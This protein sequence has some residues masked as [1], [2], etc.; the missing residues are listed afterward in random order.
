[1]IDQMTL[2]YINLYGVLGALEELTAL[3][4]VA[5]QMLRGKK[6]IRLGILVKGG[7]SA[8][9]AFEQ[10]R[11]TFIEGVER[12]DIKLAFGTPEK[13]NGM[14]AGTVTPIP[15]KG[16]THLFF[17]TKTFAKLTDRLGAFLRATPEQLDDPAFLRISTTML[18]GVIG[19]AVAQVGNHDEVGRFSASNLVDG[20]VQLSIQ[21]GPGV[22][23]RVKDHVLTCEKAR[24]DDPRA[25]MEFHD[26]RLAHDL[27]D[28]R[29]NAMA[30]IGQ[31]LIA[32]RGMISMID[33]INRMLDRVSIYLQ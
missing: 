3:D 9:L 28:G 11:C 30:C 4:P 21:D 20:A 23:V 29:V 6:P 7:P 18:L 22:A 31:Q 27:F 24:I 33:N 26:Y 12:C 13:F 32:M 15:R 8:T 2:A 10:Q 19:Q 25:V 14:I 1:M 5:Q 17:L 16:Y